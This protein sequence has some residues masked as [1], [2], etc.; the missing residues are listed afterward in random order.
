MIAIE[1]RDWPLAVPVAIGRDPLQIWRIAISSDPLPSPLSAPPRPPG[2]GGPPGPGEG[3]FL[4]FDERRRLSRFTDPSAA[5]V[6]RTMRGVLRGILGVMLGLDPGAVP[7]RLQPQGKPVMDLPPGPDRIE[8]SV[9]HCE[10]LGLIAIA[11]GRRVGIDVEPLRPLPD[12]EELAD[13]VLSPAERTA[14]A[15]LPA[16]ARHRAFLRVWTRKEALLKATGTG[17]SVDPL[18]VELPDID[19]ASV[20]EDPLR[21]RHEGIGWEL[22]ELQPDPMHVAAVAVELRL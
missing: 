11:R 13:R 21:L 7:L 22:C 5:R 15:R 16:A 4:S 2:E 17:L 6:F 19:S 18:T 12:V 20:P 8:F 10:D 3:T 14:W 1:Y 9:A